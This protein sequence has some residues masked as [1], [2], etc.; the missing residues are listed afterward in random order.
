MVA[1]ID[2]NLEE[3]YAGMDEMPT[4]A[5]TTH[6]FFAAPGGAP[7]PDASRQARL[8]MRLG[9]K[10]WAPGKSGLY[11]ASRGGAERICMPGRRRWTVR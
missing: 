9:R 7:E 10:P 6:R 11:D 8:L 2:D 4:S 3:I 1:W 5:R